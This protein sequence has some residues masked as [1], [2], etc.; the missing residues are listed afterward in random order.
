MGPGMG[1]L[2]VCDFEKLFGPPSRFHEILNSWWEKCSTKRGT[3]P[4]HFSAIP[5]NCSRVGQ[6]FQVPKKLNAL[7]GPLKVN[8]IAITG[9]ADVSNEDAKKLLGRG[10]GGRGPMCT[11]DC[12]LTTLCRYCVFALL[13]LIPPSS[14]TQGCEFTL[15]RSCRSYVRSWASIKTTL[16]PDS[17]NRIDSG[18]A[19]AGLARV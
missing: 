2:F 19:R 15:R 3:F 14:T 4:K 9:I 6:L 17:I 16:Q 10:F 18:L 11:T 5:T 8:D 1:V 12:T 7:P 13:L